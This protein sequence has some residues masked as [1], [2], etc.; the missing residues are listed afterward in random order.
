MSRDYIR[1]RS[2]DERERLLEQAA[3]IVAADASDDPPDSD[4]IDAALTHL[5]E[6]AENIQDAR[7]EIE[8]E[9]I[10][11]VANTSVLGLRYRTR[12]ESRWR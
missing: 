3:E 4:V 6:S 11:A 8:P 9:A 10:Q 5:V 1:M 12:V 7:G 2:N